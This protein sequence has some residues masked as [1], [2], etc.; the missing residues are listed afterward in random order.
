MGID[1]SKVRERL[2]ALKDK[3]GMD[4]YEFCKIYAPEKCKKNKQTATNFISAIF[5]GRNYPKETSGPEYPQLEHLQNLI[6][7]GQFPKLTMNYLLYGDD[8]P[9]IEKKV[10]DLDPNNWSLADFCEFIGRLKLNYPE[11][12]DIHESFEH[13]PSLWDEEYLSD[14]DSQKRSVSITIEEMNDI[15]YEPGT[16]VFSLGQALS[17]FHYRTKD[18]ENIRDKD[19]R[20]LGFDKAVASIRERDDYVKTNLSECDKDSPFF[21]SYGE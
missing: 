5:S 21:I 18:T 4:N 7:S 6:D 12:I 17:M 15:D 10:I 16:R 1:Y 3:S 2:A 9:A 19:I 20:Q 13:G 11:F 8:S 14:E